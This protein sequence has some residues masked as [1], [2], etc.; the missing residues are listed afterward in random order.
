LLIPAVDHCRGHIV[1][2]KLRRPELEIRVEMEATASEAFEVSP[3]SCRSPIELV[4]GLTSAQRLL[5]VVT[6]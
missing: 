6:P 2:S 4:D 5:Q 3:K 1:P